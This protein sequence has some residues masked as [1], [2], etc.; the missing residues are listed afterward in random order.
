MLNTDDKAIQK[1]KEKEDWKNRLLYSAKNRV[2][3]EC[4]HAESDD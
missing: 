3:C 1:G 4:K 2:I